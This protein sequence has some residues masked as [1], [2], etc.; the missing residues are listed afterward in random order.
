MKTQLVHII[1]ASQP[2][3]WSMTCGDVRTSLY[4]QAQGIEFNGS[5]LELGFSCS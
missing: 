4:N 2:K 1:I 5:D 3:R